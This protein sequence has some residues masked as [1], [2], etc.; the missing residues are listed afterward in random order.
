MADE[1][2]Y[3]MTATIDGVETFTGGNAKLAVSLNGSI[4]HKVKCGVRLNGETVYPN[5]DTIH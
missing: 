4:R 2:Y 5:T 3:K 1:I